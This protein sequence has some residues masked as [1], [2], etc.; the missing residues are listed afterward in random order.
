MI[1]SSSKSVKTPR[2]PSYRKKTVKTSSGIRSYAVVTFDRKDIVLAQ[3]NTQASKQEYQRVIAE[4]LAAGKVSSKQDV[5]TVSEI[6]VDYTKASKKRYQDKDGNPTEEFKTV[7]RIMRLLRSNFGRTDASE[8]KALRF[9]AIRQIIAENGVSETKPAP[10]CR[11]VVNKYCRHIIRAFKLAAENEKLSADNYQSMK[12]VETL[13]KG[14]TD[15]RETDPIKPVSL[16]TIEKTKQHLHGIAA[17]M[18]R[19]QLLTAM[20]PGEL[21]QLK[22]SCIDRSG[23]IWLFTPEHHKNEH[24]DQDRIVCIGQEA[25]DILRS[26]LLRDPNAFCFDPSEAVEQQRRKRNLE[27][28]TPSNQG[29]YQGKT[30]VKRNPKRQAGKCYTTRS[31]RRVIHRACDAAGIPRWSPNRIRKT[32]GTIIRKASGS[33]EASQAVLGHKSKSTTER[34]YAELD[35][36]LA[37][38][39]MRQ[40]G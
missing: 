11:Y 35:V 38:D 27:R 5:I 6:C 34:F 30:K 2:I 22:P 10:I 17:D 8:F 9:K 26:Y 16:E 33:L 32:A 20:R 24:R 7:Q 40:I 3:W 12:A 36:S 28:T 4:W 13:R 18:V 15:A 21:C 29:N 14:R 25:Q 19:L 1:K 39:V 31:Y 37:A 23:D